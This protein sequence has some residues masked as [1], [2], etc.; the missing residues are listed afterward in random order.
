MLMGC[1]N[2]A[3]LKETLGLNR[4]G[5]DE[6]RV[7]PRPP[8]SVPPEFNLRPPGQQESSNISGKPAEARAH[9][10]VLGLSDS[11]TPAATADTAVTPVT[12]GDLP[13]GSDAQFLADAGGSKADPQIRQKLQS[14]G[15]TGAAASDPN[16]LFGG[17]KQGDS[18]VDATKEADRIKQ[19]NAQNKPITAG[20]TPVVQPE[21]KGLLGDIF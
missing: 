10:E 16:Y 21:D 12:S 4:E 3:D 5:P 1:G 14:D 11:S 20:D 9:D 7:V 2:G 15:T 6:Y 8:L 18:V 13:S 19:D 17:K